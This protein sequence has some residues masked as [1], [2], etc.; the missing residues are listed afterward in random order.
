M[1]GMEEFMADVKFNN[2]GWSTTSEDAQTPMTKANVV[3]NLSE[4]ARIDPTGGI[5]RLLCGC[6]PSA[7]EKHQCNGNCKCAKLGKNCH[8]ILC[9][10]RGRCDPAVNAQSV[11]VGEGLQLVM[12]N[13]VNPGGDSS[14][15]AETSSDD[16]CECRSSTSSEESC[17]SHGDTAEDILEW[18]LDLMN[19]V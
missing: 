10:S 15:E 5:S 7:A 11:P 3:V 14:D 13:E 6:N 18:Y 1:A 2:R 9:G 4:H 8:P 19:D 12:A 17:G 16:D